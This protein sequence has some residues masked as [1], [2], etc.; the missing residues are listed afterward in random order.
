MTGWQFLRSRGLV[1]H[2]VFLA[3]TVV[4]AL[5]GGVELDGVPLSTTRA[6]VRLVWLA[7]VPGVLVAGFAAP[8]GDLEDRAPRR[9]MG[10]WR[11]TWFAGLLAV[12]TAIVLALRPEGVAVEGLWFVRNHALMVS[13]SLLSAQVLR[14]AAAWLPG[15]CYLLLCWFLGTHDAEGTPWWWALPAHLPY[16]P[17]A[18]AITVATTVAAGVVTFRA[19]ARTG[20]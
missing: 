12:P 18:G 8:P 10:W 15:T 7:C 3:A 5:W 20:A 6:A 1:A 17:V 11:L 14:P 19:P 4:A 13:L 2:G 9:P 16:A